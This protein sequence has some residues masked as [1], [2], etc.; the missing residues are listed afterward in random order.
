MKSLLTAYQA[1]N[2]H[3][4]VPKGQTGTSSARIGLKN[5]MKPPRLVAADVYVVRLANE[6]P[7]SK[8]D[9]KRQAQKQKRS[10][11]HQQENEFTGDDKGDS[12][13]A[14]SGLSAS[15]VSLHDELTCIK[16]TTSDPP[17][18]YIEAPHHSR[19]V[20]ESRPCYRCVSYMHSVGIKRVFWTTN[21]GKW[22]GAKV[23]DLVRTWEQKAD[24]WAGLATFAILRSC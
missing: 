13:S 10:E 12:C 15:K 17:L 2:N 24:T 7:G 16:N 11:Q 22:E 5:R 18:A 20:A 3:L 21:E 8:L 14:P 19:V 4:L 9:K 1:R 23:R 6:P